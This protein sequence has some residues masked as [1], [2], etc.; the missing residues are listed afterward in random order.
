MNKSATGAH[1]MLSNTYC[2]RTCLEW[3]QCFKVIFTTKTDIA[4]EERRF[5]MME[6]SRHYLMKTLLKVNENRHN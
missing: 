5:S 4:V 3:L 1:R 6:N 2:D